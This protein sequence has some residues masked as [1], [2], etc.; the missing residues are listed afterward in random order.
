MN[1]LG[2]EVTGCIMVKGEFLVKGLFLGFM[3]FRKCLRVVLIG[4]GVYNSC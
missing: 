1:F 2:L 3:S 4:E